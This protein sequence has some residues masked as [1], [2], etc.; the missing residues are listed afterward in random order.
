MNDTVTALAD[1]LALLLLDEQGQWATRRNLDGLFAVTLMVELAH[2]DRLELFDED[3]RVFVEDDSPTGSAALDE[4]LATLEQAKGS[5]IKDAIAA[6]APGQKDRVL[7][8]LAEQGAVEKRTERKRLIF[9]STT[10]LL[11]DTARR[12]EVKARLRPLLFDEPDGAGRDEVF[13]ALLSAGGMVKSVA[14]RSKSAARIAEEV[15]ARETVAH[16]IVSAGVQGSNE[17]I[18]PNLM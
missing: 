15:W 5:V 8:R 1:D 2:L 16:E 18:M 7:S 10:W 14:G 12:D 3:N 13:I 6:L 17:G 4:A 9:T 11:A